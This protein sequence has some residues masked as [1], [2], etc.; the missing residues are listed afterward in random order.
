MFAVNATGREST[1][2]MDLTAFGA[3]GEEATVWT[4]ADTRKDSEPDATS[5]FV[6]L[7]SAKFPFRFAPLSLTVIRWHVK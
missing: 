2:L 1:R 4:L 3:E 5:S 7:D 6:S